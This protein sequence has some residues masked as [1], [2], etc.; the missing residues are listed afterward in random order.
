MEDSLVTTNTIDMYIEFFS[1]IINNVT[2][3]DQLVSKS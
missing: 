1:T 3:D 2:E